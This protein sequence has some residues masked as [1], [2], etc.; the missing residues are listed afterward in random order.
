MSIKDIMMSYIPSSTSEKI[1]ETGC[2]LNF[3]G[4]NSGL[5]SMK[6]K[7]PEI[8]TEFCLGEMNIKDKIEATML[9]VDSLL[10]DITAYRNIQNKNEEFIYSDKSLLLLSDVIS[11]HDIGIALKCR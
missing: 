9:Y 8:E 4:C 3:K 11:G 10:D 7:S 5:I 6:F 1:N 2:E